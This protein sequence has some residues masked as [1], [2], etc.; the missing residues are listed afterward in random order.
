MSKTRVGVV[1]AGWIATVHCRVLGRFDDVSVAAIA[2]RR[3]ESAAK[4]AGSVGGPRTRVF[5]DY[6]SMLDG[7]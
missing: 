1:G 3:P 7:G 6:R 5:E 4:L 2:S